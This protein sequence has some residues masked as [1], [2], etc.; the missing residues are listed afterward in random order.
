MSEFK[1]Q[2]TIVQLEFL[3]RFEIIGKEY[4]LGRMQVGKNS[5]KRRNRGS[6]RQKNRL[7]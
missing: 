6:K 1:D 4:Q 3:I 5:L 2:K 7:N